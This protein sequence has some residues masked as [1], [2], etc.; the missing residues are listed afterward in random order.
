MERRH[1]EQR[2]GRHRLA[3]QPLGAMAD[4]F[5]RLFAG[6]RRAHHL[7]DI[8]CITYFQ[9][10]HAF[11][12]ALCCHHPPPGLARGEPDDR[13]RRTIQQPQRPQVN[14]EAAEYWI[15]RLGGV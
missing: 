15:P 11:I 12:S 14:I 13:L 4:D 3:D 7:L 8:G 2:I 10:I 5:Q 1:I 9:G 6:E